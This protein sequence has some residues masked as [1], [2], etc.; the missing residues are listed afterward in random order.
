V[1]Y[2]SESTVGSLPIDLQVFLGDVVLELGR[3]KELFPRWPTDPLHALAVLSE[4][5][6][7]LTK[8]ILQLMYEPEKSGRKNVRAELVQTAAM[9]LR[10]ALSLD[11][12][13]YDFSAGL[14]HAQRG[15]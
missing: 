6:G 12:H 7:E 5:H 10:M 3:A 15:L 9:C 8:A 14:Q 4:E 2:P 13:H 11:N 1:S